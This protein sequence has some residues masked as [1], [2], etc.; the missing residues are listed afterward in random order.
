MTNNVRH[1]IRDDLD[2]ICLNQSLL[3]MPP[4]ELWPMAIH[5]QRVR[6]DVKEVL[7]ASL[8]KGEIAKTCLSK[9]N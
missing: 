2:I 8:F 4:I 1:L 6:S 3:K 9:N 5:R 7:L